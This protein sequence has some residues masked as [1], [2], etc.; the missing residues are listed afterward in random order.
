MKS[1]L[2][3]VHEAAATLQRDYAYS[4]YNGMLEVMCPQESGAVNPW[5]WRVAGE[6]VWRHWD[7]YEPWI[8]AKHLQNEAENDYNYLIALEE[9]R[10]TYHEG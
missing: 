5:V 6:T 2:P 4:M 1:L 3:D 8:N 7:E 9:I 10:E